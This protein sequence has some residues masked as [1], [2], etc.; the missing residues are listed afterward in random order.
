[1]GL[2]LEGPEFVEDL[3]GCEEFA[4]YV[5]VVCG[6]MMFRPL[7]RIVEW[8]WTPV[9]SKLCLCKLHHSQSKLMSMALVRFG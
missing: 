7:V 6:W 9:E 4:S 5:L 2:L 3:L 8:A 1:M